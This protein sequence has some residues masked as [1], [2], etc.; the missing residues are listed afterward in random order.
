MVPKKT[1]KK[2][3]KEGMQQEILIAAKILGGASK[4]HHP[5]PLLRLAIISLINPKSIFNSATLIDKKFRH[6]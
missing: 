4:C 1:N 2:A 6:L 3:A 5:I